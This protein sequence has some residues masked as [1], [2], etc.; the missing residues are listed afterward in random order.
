MEPAF[1][2]WKLR[3][4]INDPSAC[5]YHEVAESPA[6]NVLDVHASSPLDQLETVIRKLE[7]ALGK[8]KHEYGRITVQADELSDDERGA[9]D[10][11]LMS[12]H[13]YGA[14][15]HK[16]ATLTTDT[17]PTLSTLVDI[18]DEYPS[19]TRLAA[20]ICARLLGS[21]AALY[22]RR[23]T[24]RFDRTKPVTIFSFRGVKRERLPLLYAHLFDAITD[25]VWSPDR[26]TPAQPVVLIIDEYYF[27]KSVPSMEEEVIKATKTGRARRFCVITADQNVS[28]YY[29]KDSNAGALITGNARQKF[30]FELKEET[31]ILAT[32]YDGA[33]GVA[34]LQQI[35]AL[36]RGQ[37]VAMLGPDVRTLDIELTPLERRALLQ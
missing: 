8:P 28:T 19:A 3:D 15:G 9:L 34:H 1:H 29:G 14:K 5:T 17:T 23:T 30:F 26:D 21:A 27:M 11:A 4:A 24:L 2:G 10:L 13:I 31:D 32:A 7:T 6:I 18:L 33:L 36:D 35:R 12:E 25:H 37:C 16:L 22:D 20:R